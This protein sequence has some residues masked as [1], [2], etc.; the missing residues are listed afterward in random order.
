VDQQDSASQMAHRI[1]ER[2]KVR[3]DTAFSMNEAI[4]EAQNDRNRVFAHLAAQNDVMSGFATEAVNRVYWH[5]RLTRV[6]VISSI[7]SVAPVATESI[8]RDTRYG[9]STV[10]NT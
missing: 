7:A 6:P 4:R 10:Y 1:N 2:K 3:F 5:H 9:R 8:E